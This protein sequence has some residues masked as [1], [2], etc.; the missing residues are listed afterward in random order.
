[1]MMLLKSARLFLSSVLFSVI[2]STFLLMGCTNSTSSNINAP[3]LGGQPPVTSQPISQKIPTTDQKESS[4]KKK[5]QKQGIQGE[6]AAIS[7]NQ[8]PMIGNIRKPS[9][10]EA[11]QTTVWIFPGS[12]PAQTPRIKLS[13]LQSEYKP[14]KQVKTDSRGN[15][16]AQLPPGKYTV[17]AQYGEDLYLNSFAGDGTYSTVEVSANQMSQVRLVN[18]EKATF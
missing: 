11:V 6:V 3:N 14:I 8:M 15:F 5:R 7:G 12:I 1:M 18:S 17:F 13:A 10:P 4:E 9:Q 2:I 16:F